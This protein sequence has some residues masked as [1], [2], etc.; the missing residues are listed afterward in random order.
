MPIPPLILDLG[1]VLN[2]LQ[3]EVKDWQARRSC[4]AESEAKL[5]PA[6]Q[7]LDVSRFIRPTSEYRSPPPYKET[8]SANASLVEDLS[9]TRC[10]EKL[11]QDTDKLIASEGPGSSL[12]APSYSSSR[13]DSILPPLTSPE[14]Q[15]LRTRLYTALEST[16]TAQPS[17]EQLALKKMED[18]IA[19]LR[20]ALANEKEQR[21]QQLSFAKQD[22][23]AEQERMEMEMVRLQSTH[24]EEKR[25]LKQHQEAELHNVL[26]RLEKTEQHQLALQ[27]QSEKEKASAT[28]AQ[29]K[30]IQELL[31]TQ[32]KQAEQAAAQHEQATLELKQA[33]EAQA[34]RQ[35]QATLELKQAHEAQISR[36]EQ[37]LHEHRLNPHATFLGAPD[38][39]DSHLQVNEEVQPPPSA[40]N[41]SPPVPQSHS[42]EQQQTS[43][44][45]ATETLQQVSPQISQVA[46]GQT[47]TPLPD[48]NL[49]Q[50]QPNE[51]EIAVG[52]PVGVK[53]LKGARGVV[54]RIDF[55]KELPY[56]VKLDAGPKIRVH[57]SNLERLHVDLRVADAELTEEETDPPRKN[58]PPRGNAQQETTPSQAPAKEN[59]AQTKENW[60]VDNKVLV[61]CE[62]RHAPL[63]GVCRILVYSVA[64]SWPRTGRC[65]VF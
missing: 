35:E 56:G 25:L 65:S 27:S 57:R 14:A 58:D 19:Q 46:T 60:K 50:A 33:H 11:I 6:S 8:Q 4:L 41:L 34:A 5:P 63:E 54:N 53:S 47:A 42:E 62:G 44:T 22:L 15:Q 64:G 32:A 36:L 37:L 31:S 18:E 17:P 52:D 55:R 1:R 2:R 26:T 59:Q 61:F 13:D 9:Q 29:E 45:V 16:A 43:N 48:Q 28:S 38:P 20:S 23:Q 24:L 39:E 49:N 40:P 3:A 10:H 30:L 21:Q 51:P 12:P 7:T